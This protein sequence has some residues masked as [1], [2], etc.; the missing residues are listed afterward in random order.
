[1]LG[2]GR[3]VT[4]EKAAGGEIW[5][6]D[7]GSPSCGALGCRDT[8]QGHCLHLWDPSCLPGNS[9]VFSAQ[10]VRAGLEGGL[11]CSLSAVPD[12]PRMPGF[13]PK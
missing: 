12:H 10:L 3:Q 8:L 1:M 9:W 11:C 2:V 7:R 6:R 13:H 4:L 5:G